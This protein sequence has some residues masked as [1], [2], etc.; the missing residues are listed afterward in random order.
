MLRSEAIRIMDEVK[1]FV[2][3]FDDPVRFIAAMLMSIEEGCYKFDLDIREIM[4]QMTASVNLV[5]D[6]FGP[7]DPGKEELD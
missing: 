1:T 2:N 3:K 6:V 7:Y 5:N 4:D